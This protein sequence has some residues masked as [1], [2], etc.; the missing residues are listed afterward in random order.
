MGLFRRPSMSDRMDNAAE[1]K[2]WKKVGPLGV[3]MAKMDY[4]MDEHEGRR[5]RHRASGRQPYRG[6]RQETDNRGRGFWGNKR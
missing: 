1:R 2:H 4:L 3:Q 6:S 5:N